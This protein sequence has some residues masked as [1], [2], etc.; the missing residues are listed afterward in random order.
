[1]PSDLSGQ[2]MTKK[3]ACQQSFLG[4]SFKGDSSFARPDQVDKDG[5]V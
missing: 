4:V 5:C 2:Y 3:F 1:M